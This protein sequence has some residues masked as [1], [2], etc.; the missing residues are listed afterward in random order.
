MKKLNKI[1][2][3]VGGF[4]LI[5]AVIVQG[6]ILFRHDAGWYR[7]FYYILS[8]LGFGLLLCIG[9]C[10]VEMLKR[11]RFIVGEVLL[12]C[13]GLIISSQQYK[14]AIAHIDPSEDISGM[15]YCVL[16]PFVVCILLSFVCNFF[17]QRKTN[18]A[19]N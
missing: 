19:G 14:S 5:I 18:C 6:C 10:L 4:V 12:L 16:V 7:N 1:D 11:K 13:I 9:Y 8:A 2:L 17:G 15:N 3:L